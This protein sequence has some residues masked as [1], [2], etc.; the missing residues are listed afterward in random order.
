MGCVVIG[1][2]VAWLSYS[3]GEGVKKKQ[4]ACLVV[5]L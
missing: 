2:W 3:W 5:F 1:K 4:D